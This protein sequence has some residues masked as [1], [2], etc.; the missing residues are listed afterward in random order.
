MKATLPL[1]L[2]IAA[3]GS[4]LAQTTAAPAPKAA[5]LSPLTVTGIV[6]DL[7]ELP[8]SAAV[9]AGEDFRARGYT[10]LKQ[11]AAT[12]PGVFVRDED[13]FGNFPNISIRGVDGTRSAKVTLMED[14]IL[15]AP[16]PYSAPNAYYS[17]KSGRMAGIE[18]LKGSSQVMYGPHTTG[19]VVNF[20]STP[21]PTE[22]RRFFSR[23][24][25]GSYGNVFNQTWLGGVTQTEAG[26]VGAL[27]E[28]HTQLS[29]GFRQIDGV[30]RRS[31]YTLTEPM[32]KLSWEPS[33]GLR[34]RFELKVGQTDFDA[35]ESYA[36]LSEADL[37]ARPDR[38]YASS[39]FDHH[40]AE[41]WRTYL[42]W[43]AEPDKSLRLDSALYF[44]RFDR[45]WDKLDGITPAPGLLSNIGEALVHA[46]SLALLR[47]DRVTGNDGSFYTNKALRQ[48][49]AYGWQG[50]VT[51]RLEAGAVRHELTAGLRIHR[52]DAGGSN[53]RITYAVDDGVI[54]AGTPGAVSSAGY[55]QTVA[56]A[57]FI[58]DSIRTGALT[59]RPG[60][61]YEY[62]NMG[63]TSAAG[64]YAPTTN[65]MVM[66]GLGFTC[67]LNAEHALFGGV[68]RGGSA[69]NPAGYAAGARSESSLGKELG[70]RGR[71]GATSWELIA[72]HTDFHD[73]IAPV[74]GV[75]GGGLLAVTNGG[76]AV[77]YGL[78]ALL[79]HDLAGGERGYKVPV[80]AGL[81]WTHA[82]F[83]D[84]V[85]SRL[86]NSAGIFAGAEDGHD[87]PYIPEWKLAAGAG[88][89][90][91][92]YA[93]S[94]DLS[95]YSSTWGTGYNANPRL[96]DGTNALAD[97]SA[98][99]GRVDGL[100]T[101]DLN[102]RWQCTRTFRVVGG[103]Q[104]L[105]DRRAIISRAPLGGRANAPRTL[106]LGGELAF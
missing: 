90:S 96:V 48:H 100:L 35:D 97:P 66:G 85:G 93:G 8:G 11:I 65:A 15:T 64:A 42:K 30:G 9:V 58:E 74:V 33:G 53:Q 57:F 54:G 21:I 10:N 22:E 7:F 77:S 44:N 39:R 50:A 68:Y 45:M 19:G 14:G 1:V 105:L 94:L 13:G 73:L 89:E 103:V 20:L 32:V 83:K 87:I 36:G 31:G 91:G 17:P 18:F 46:P 101:V 29:D 78:E 52:D 24:T 41:Q 99:D 98:I 26:K 3:N 95:Y 37:R 49:E 60:L 102:L 6:P 55:Q 25:A 82:R 5:Q 79:R 16:S 28:L 70:W 62:L 72:F 80:Y 23:L 38:R 75:A 86:G 88:L 106:F 47:G 12:A 59:L 27:V 4:A 84:I 43:S 56:T 76:G 51:K 34:Q 81:T 69:A 92:P 67:A 40:V 61:R 63:S 2:L 104:N 71:K